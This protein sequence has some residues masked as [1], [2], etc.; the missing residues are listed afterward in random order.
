MLGYNS[1]VNVRFSKNIRRVRNWENNV[2]VATSTERPDLGGNIRYGD[3]NTFA[4]I[5]WNYLIDCFGVS[6]MLDVGCGEGHAVRFF[7]KHGV[8]SHGIDGLLS[9]VQRAVYPIALHDLLSGPY[10]MPVDLVWSC[11]V[12]EHIIPEKVD[13]FLETLA[14]GK[15]V[16]MTHAQPGQAGYHHVN[17]QPD[18]YWISAMARY[19]YTLAR[20]QPIFRQIAEKELCQNYFQSSGLV[21]VRL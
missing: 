11:E 12:T 20:T 19:G 18:D 6:S 2:S 15:V 13:Y 3:A 5:L 10:I 14:N 1:W 16:A 21:F 4:P 17:C 8:H 9:N 7:A